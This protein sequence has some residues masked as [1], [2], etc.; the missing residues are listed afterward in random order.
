MR[1][2]AGA[3]LVLLALPALAAAQ[4]DPAREPGRVPVEIRR[5]EV[6]PEAKV[7]RP[8]VP[9][10]AQDPASVSEAERAAAAFELV[11]RGQQ[12]I[13]GETRPMPRR[14]DLGY[15]VYGGIQQKNLQRSP[16]R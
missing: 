7:G 1:R 12:F 16:P 11:R 2:T 10:P 3:L 8:I 9:P 6:S 13:R 14:P 15:D 5:G 4:S